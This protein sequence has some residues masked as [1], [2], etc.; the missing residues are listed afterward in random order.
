MQWMVSR[1]EKRAQ[2]IN[3]GGINPL[4][5]NGVA[6]LCLGGIGGGGGVCGGR[7]FLFGWIGGDGEAGSSGRLCRVKVGDIVEWV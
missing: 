6:A 2:A 7:F 3:R 1:G 4:P 5:T